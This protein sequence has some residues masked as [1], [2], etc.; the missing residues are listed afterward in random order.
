MLVNR[1]E[2]NE[3]VE[4]LFKSSNVLKSTYNTTTK[5]LVISFNSG[6]TY[7][8]ENVPLKDYLRLEIS[9]S[10]G[11]VV[12]KTFKPYKCTKIENINP[13]P[14]LEQVRL[15]LEENG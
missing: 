13:Q 4:C 3:L 7:E 6:A 2:E 5:K 15:I 8:Y 1:K 14:L 9:E 10:Q 12:N 11:T